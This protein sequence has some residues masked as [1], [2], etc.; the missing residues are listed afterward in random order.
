MKTPMKMTTTILTML[1]LALL[2]SCSKKDPL[3]G[4]WTDG[5][6]AATL[7]LMTKEEGKPARVIMDDGRGTSLM[8]TWEMM[9]ENK[10]SL[11][12]EFKNPLGVSTPLVQPPGTTTR[13]TMTRVKD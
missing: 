4:K 8:G 12:M 13:E 5:N 3:V 6:K 2:P 11:L 10:D 1:V 9:G 7:E